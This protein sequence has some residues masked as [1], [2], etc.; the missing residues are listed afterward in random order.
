MPLRVLQL[1]VE[2]FPYAKVGGLADVMGALPKAL[3]SEGAEVTVILPCYRQVD[4]AKFG[5]ERVPVPNDWKVPVGSTAYG[6]GLLR[7]K[8]PGS[9]ADVAFLENDHFFDRFSVYNAEGG[10]AFPDDAERWIFYQRGS[11]EACRVLD[12]KPDVIH[13][14]ESQTGLVPL[15]VRGLRQEAFPG[16]AC[17]Y[18]I[19][20]LAYQGAYGPEVAALA[21]FDSEWMRRGSPLE[22]HGTV[23]MMKAAIASAHAVTT[24]SPTYAREIQ[25][26]E[27][28]CGLQ[29]VLRSRGGDLSG[30]LNGIDTD[31]W[32]PQKDKRIARNYDVGDREGK[33]ACKRALLERMGLPTASEGKP[34]VA[35]VGRLVPQKGCD[36]FESVLPNVLQHDV[37]LIAL[38]SGADVFEDLLRTLQRQFPDKMRAAIGFDDELAHQIQAGADI[39]LMPS[40]YEPC[41]LNQ[42]YAMA[43]GTVP[44][45][46]ATGGLSDTVFELPPGAKGA[47]G[48]SFHD[49]T[50]DAFKEACYRALVAF[51]DRPRWEALIRNGMTRDFTWTRSAREYIALY[52]RALAAARGA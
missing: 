10:R 37:L 52:E 30:I 43:Y 51:Q 2:A 24:V 5:L 15:Y 46:R 4:R 33:R 14:H 31:V 9:Q 44:V 38:G 11:L 41:G 12:L 45:A 1:G 21:G 13:A 26:K 6:F 27:E 34:L 39:L 47:T 16:A 36:L 7:G 40:R 32:S 35:F 17:I 49:Y 20:N 19:H 25:G 3:V 18:T 29:D 8:L 28:G 22:F 23:N 50:T 42:M 48:F